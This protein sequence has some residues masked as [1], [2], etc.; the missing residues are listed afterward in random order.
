MLIKNPKPGVRKWLK[1]GAVALFVIEGA[2]F[3]GS[4]FLWYRVNTDRDTR[5]Y[6]YQNYPSVLEA[7]YKIGETFDPQNQIRQID[8]AYWNKES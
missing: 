1:R 5:K 4:Y 8:L 6:L 7:Y 3:V 2:S